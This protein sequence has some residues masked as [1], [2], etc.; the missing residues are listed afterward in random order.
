[1]GALPIPLFDW[2]QAKAAKATAEQT[3]ARHE[4]V[5]VQRKIIE[6]VRKA[7]AGYRSSLATL[8]RATDELLPLQQKRFEQAQAAYRAGETDLVSLLTAEGSL[9]EARE[10]L[11]ELR[12]K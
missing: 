6:E 10:K 1:A 5:D 11:I 7:H 8:R 9:D 2:G 3:A 12:K 4:L